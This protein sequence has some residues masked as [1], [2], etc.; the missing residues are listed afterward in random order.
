MI[1]TRKIFSDKSTI[2]NFNFKDV[3]TGYVLEDTVR[4]LKI[5]T[6]TAIPS[7]RY[8]VIITFSQRFQRPL[9]LLLNVPYYS[10]IRIHPG[11]IPANT[12]GCL[13]LG[14]TMMADFVGHSREAMAEFQPLLEAELKIGKVYI[15]IL[16]GYSADEWQPYK[17]TGVIQNA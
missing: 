5:P 11:N 7:G 15:D 4:R 3:W 6:V 10:G 8:E 12:D 13:L 9:P 17:P 1:L 2:G 16:G 14:K